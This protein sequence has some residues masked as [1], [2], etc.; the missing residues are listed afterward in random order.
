KAEILEH[1]NR[2]A[3]TQLENLFAL[4]QTKVSVYPAAVGKCG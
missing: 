3:Q 4:T 2:Q 1:A